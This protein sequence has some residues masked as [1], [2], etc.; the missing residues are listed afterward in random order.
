[1]P[2]PNLLKYS[3]TP[4]NISIKSGNYAIGVA[5]GTGYGPTASTNYWQGISPPT[6]GYTIYE[7]K[8]ANGPSIRV[9]S[10]S[11]VLID[12]ANRLYSGSSIT[13]EEG[14]LTYFNS[15]NTVIC[16]N[17][18][19]EEIVTSGLTFLLDAG[20][21]PSYPKS[22]TSWTDLSFSGNNTTLVN[23]P[24][25][26]SSN[27]GSI[28]FDGTNDYGNAG[29]G[30]RIEN[31]LTVAAWVNPSSFA[32]QGNVQC[33]NS[34][35]GYRM[36][37]QSDGTFWMYSNGNTITSPS[38]YSLN[39]WYY[40][41]G[42]FS[43][44]G[45]RMYINGSLVQSN[46]TPFSPSYSFAN[47]IVGGFST[48]QEL[49]Q[50]RIANLSIYNRALSATEVLQNYNAQKYRY[51]PFDPDAQAFIT[52]ANIT[53]QTQKIAIDQ[54]VL[55]LKSYSL[56]TKFSAIYPFV[57]GT[58]TSHKYNLKDPRDLDAAYRIQFNGGWTHN[59]NGI[60]G[61]GTNGYADTFAKMNTAAI[62]NRLN[63][64]SSYTRTIPSD[65]LRYVTGI[66]NPS[67]FICFGYAAVTGNFA[68]GL[69]TNQSIGFGLAA[70]FFNGTVTSDSVGSFYRNGVFVDSQ[71][72]NSMTTQ[73][74][75]F[76]GAMNAGFPYDYNNTN[77][78]FTSL[79]GAL[80]ATDAANFY[81]AVQAFQ[82]TLGRQV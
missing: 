80:T 55:N 25:Y 24:T 59:S 74:S 15:L 31:N 13:T 78:A 27:G 68:L 7:N 4:D 38:T 29:T 6:S 23:G 54:L 73:N 8:S 18:D 51:I 17:I 82:T 16:T 72:P 49:F 41:V 36:R 45:L 79:G 62:P 63:H 46:S 69:Q 52:A 10:S 47:F 9:P 14:A 67:P 44:T 33:Q 75:Y 39:N 57:G 58:A 81:T 35:Q 26:N 53:N 5:S 11:A 28:S 1:M 21:T 2:T 42:V 48:T 60:T 43:S 20:F 61:N 40:T 32:N 56:W 71:T 37:F 70:G 30:L 77:F 34:N 64:W 76:L 3:T 22:G 12:Y 19:Y 50:G 65:Y 66:L